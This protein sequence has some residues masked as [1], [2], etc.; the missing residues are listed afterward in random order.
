MTPQQEKVTELKQSTRT[1]WN[2]VANHAEF[3]ALMAA[4]AKFVI[5]AT[6]FFMV[7]YFALPALVGYA[8][9]LMKTPVIGPV[10]LAYLFALSQFF[11]V[12]FVAF[13]Y[14]RAAA[15]FDRMAKNVLDSVGGKSK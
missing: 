7:Y 8:P 11:M 14:M 5:P 1:D 10:N 13:L 2:R 9:E 4:K 12:W 15:K 3:K 6:V